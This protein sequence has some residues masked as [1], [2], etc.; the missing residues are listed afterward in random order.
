MIPP[1]CRRHTVTARAP[2]TLLSVQ[3][4]TAGFDVNGRF[5]P[6]VSNVSFSVDAGETLCIVGESGS[7]KSVTALSIIG[8]L[9]PPGRVSNGSCHIQWP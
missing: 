7:G 9:P 5:V 4:L 6:A 3:H 1:G 8:L 2:D